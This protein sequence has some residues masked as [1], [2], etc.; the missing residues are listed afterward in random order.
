M[1]NTDAN[2]I[3]FYDDTDG[4]PT[5]PVL[6]VGQ[7]SVSDAIGGIAATDVV[8]TNRPAHVPGLRIYETDTGVSYISSGGAWKYLTGSPTPNAYTIGGGGYQLYYQQAVYAASITIPHT[9]LW[10]V[11]VEMNISTFPTIATFFDTILWN[12]AGFQ[13]GG[14]V[15]TPALV[16]NT[17]NSATVSFTRLLAINAGSVL[18]IRSKSWALGGSQDFGDQTI[19]AKRVG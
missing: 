14:I 1:G 13:V 8:S 15:R 18:T 4:A 2:G 19:Y 16:P 17:N 9:G 11:H 5:A 3:Y 7:Q 12:N 6:N 10:E